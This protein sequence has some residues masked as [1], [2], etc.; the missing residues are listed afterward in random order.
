[1]NPHQKNVA[2]SRNLARPTSTTK[3]K[4]LAFFHAPG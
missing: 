3:G 2:L 4:H 1:M